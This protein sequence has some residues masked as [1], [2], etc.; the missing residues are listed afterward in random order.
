MRRACVILCPTAGTAVSV[1]TLREHLRPLLDAHWEVRVDVSG[2]PGGTKALALKAVR[3]GFDLV[4]AA[5]GD[6]T[7]SE[8]LQALVGTQ[9]ALGVLPLGTGNVWAREVG[10][11]LDL[12][13]AVRVLLAGRVR[14]VD[15]GRAGQR[16]F[17]LMAG[18]G[19]DAA[20][21]RQLD[22]HSKRRLGRVAYLVAG[23][24]VAFSFLGHRVLLNV[25]GV[26]R[27]CRA[28]LIVIGN[29]RLYGG[30]VNVT[31]EARIDD[32]LL[33]VCVFKGAGLPAVAWHIV[34]VL[35]GRHVHDPGVDYFRAR[36]L[37]VV[38]DSPLP[39]QVDGD[40]I[41]E[42][43]MAF[44]VRARSLNVLVPA[45]MR[46]DLFSERDDAASRKGDGGG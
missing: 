29:S 9:V 6:G 46:P 45:D 11:P 35:L 27:S 41:G 2:A 12:P 16:Y 5:G 38:G 14:R 1:E 37:T 15:V 10:I 36:R 4:V 31:V 22:A 24:A 13:G 43:P 17:L 40:S 8:A 44:A 42:T 21:T 18:I 19:F 39:V 30:D 28:L 32:G 33:D 7:V 25:D 3:E 20:V 26:R 34:W 23:V